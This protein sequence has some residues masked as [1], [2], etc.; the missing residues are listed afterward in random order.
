MVAARNADEREPDTD[1][2]FT[3]KYLPD[4]IVVQQHMVKDGRL[5]VTVRLKKRKTPSEIASPSQHGD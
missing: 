1:I 2:L 3:G 5:H 4:E